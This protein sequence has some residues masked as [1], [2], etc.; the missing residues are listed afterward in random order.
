MTLRNKNNIWLLKFQSWYTIVA[1]VQMG[2]QEN[3]YVF[4]CNFKPFDRFRV[5]IAKKSLVVFLSAITFRETS[6]ACRIIEAYR[7][8]P[9]R[10]MLSVNAIAAQRMLK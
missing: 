3:R 6:A 10:W 7:R 1:E 4:Y 5:S 9:V 8:K 2:N